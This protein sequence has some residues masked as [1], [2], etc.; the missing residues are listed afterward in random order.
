MI[1]PTFKNTMPFIKVYNKK[2]QFYPTNQLFEVNI[3]KK[4]DYIS[5]LL[6]GHIMS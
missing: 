5:F 3:V 6:K 4:S 1:R 2:K